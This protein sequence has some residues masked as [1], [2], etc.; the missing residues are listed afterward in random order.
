MYRKNKI[1]IYIISK[2]Q[3]KETIYN[4]IH[5]YTFCVEKKTTRKNKKVIVIYLFKFLF[6]F[7]F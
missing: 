5:I 3:N 2:Q 1:Y 6:S 4:Y 7:F